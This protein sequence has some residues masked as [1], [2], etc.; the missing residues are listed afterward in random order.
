MS[1]LYEPARS[2]PW[3]MRKDSAPLFLNTPEGDAYK[4]S[5]PDGSL[6]LH[7]ANGRIVGYQ[8]PAKREPVVRP[9]GWSVFDG[10][11]CDPEVTLQPVSEEQ[12]ASLRARLK[13][14]EV[15]PNVG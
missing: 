11:K 14:A 4:A 12:A 2:A 8:P 1:E 3:V 5:L 6:L 7:E 9:A 15:P 13:S 10:A